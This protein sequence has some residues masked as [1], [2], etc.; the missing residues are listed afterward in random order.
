LEVI[1]IMKKL[2]ILGITVLVVLSLTGC[3]SFASFFPYVDRPE[4]P[5]ASMLVLEAGK[6]EEQRSS[7]LLNSNASG[8]APWV[9]DSNGNVIPFRNLDSES[10]LDSL[11]YSE[12]LKAGTYTLK[13]FYHVYIDYSL[14]PSGVIASYGPFENYSYHIKQEFPLEKPV[15]ISLREAEMTTFGRYYIEAN[16]KEGLAGTGDD[17]WKINPSTVKISSDVNDKKALRVIKN[18]YTDKWGEWNTRNKEQAADK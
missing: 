2:G 11:Y 7:N 15:T 13:G 6:L 14:L 12:N 8:W 4:S 16:W 18:W 5:T 1:F 3:L 17:R 9:V 10:R